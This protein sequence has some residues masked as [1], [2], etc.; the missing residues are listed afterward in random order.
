MPIAPRSRVMAMIPTIRQNKYPREPQGSF[1]NASQS[2]LS[3]AVA[4]LLDK[5]VIKMNSWKEEA[6]MFSV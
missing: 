1:E 5:T 3:F 6:W 4:V 2:I